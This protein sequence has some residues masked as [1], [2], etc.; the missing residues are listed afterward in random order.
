MRID[1]LSHRPTKPYHSIWLSHLTIEK[2]I[3]RLALLSVAVYKC[4]QGVIQ[5]IFLSV[6]GFYDISHKRHFLRIFYPMLLCFCKH[7]RFEFGW[8]QIFPIVKS[9]LTQFLN[10]GGWFYCIIIYHR[11]ACCESLENFQEKMCGW[12]LF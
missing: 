9:Y 6:V 3:S 12:V 4:N 8:C 10:V 7:D 11:N 5:K 1:W 2:L